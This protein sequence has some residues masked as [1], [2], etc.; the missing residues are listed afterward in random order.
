MEKLLSNFVD[1]RSAFINFRN[2]KSNN[3]FPLL[4]GV[5][6][7]G[8]VSPILYILYNHDI[9]ESVD[10]V[11]NSDVH[12]ADDITQIICTYGKKCHRRHKLHIEREINRINSYERKWRI[13][14][15][16]EKFKVIPLDNR[17]QWE[18][19][20]QI[21]GRNQNYNRNGSFLG[22]KLT[23]SGYK[24]HFVHRSILANQQLTKLSRFRLLDQKTKRQ[25]YL[26]LVRPLLEY[27]A[28]PLHLGARSNILKLQRVQNRATKFITNIYY[29]DVMTSEALHRRCDLL[30][31]NQLLHIRA[32][33]IWRKI[34]AMGYDFSVR[35][36]QQMRGTF[37]VR[38][39]SSREKALGPE[40]PPIFK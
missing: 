11:T 32:R 20:L 10:P 25:L 7:G 37:S 38:Y 30:P 28:V 14:T 17:K 29:P 24:S 8:C 16:L 15:S 18:L 39:P 1:A 23:T 19:P 36:G 2:Y 26:S 5:T 12:F 35:L 9:P 6:Q 34:D 27:P 21:D 3:S 22:L 33:D 40:P 13:S 4:Y 31:I